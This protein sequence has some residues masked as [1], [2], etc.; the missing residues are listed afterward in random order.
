MSDANN[1]RNLD[2]DEKEAIKSDA[3]LKGREDNKGIDPDEVASKRAAR[4]AL[5]QSAHGDVYIVKT[6][7]EDDDVRNSTPGMRE[8]P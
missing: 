3:Q 4:E 2:I 1:D 7:L 6:D 8:Q 5:G